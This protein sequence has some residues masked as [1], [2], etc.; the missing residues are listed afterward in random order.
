MYEREVIINAGHDAGVKWKS[1][2]LDYRLRLPFALVLPLLKRPY[3]LHKMKMR[4]KKKN[5]CFPITIKHE[6]DRE[7]VGE[8]DLHILIVC[9]R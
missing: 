4:E 8:R 1:N 2:G 3:L 6:D 9:R 5:I 7:G